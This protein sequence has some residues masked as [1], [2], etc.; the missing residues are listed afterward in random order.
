M[1]NRFVNR[2]DW[3]ATKHPV[4]RKLHFE[5]IYKNKGKRMNLKWSMKPVLTIHS[6]GLMVTPSILPTTQTFRQPPRKRIFQEDQLDSFRIH[7]KINSLDDLNQSHSPPG[8]EFRQFEGCVIFDRLKFDNDSRFPTILESIRI[9][10]ELHVQLQYNSI[11]L[12][13]PS[14]VV[15]GHSAKFDK[16]SVLE[17]FPPTLDQ[18]L[19]KINKFYLA[20]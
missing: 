7:D 16:L 4:L 15:N 9:D 17:N 8:F 14:W 6:A 1:E 19:S 13:L 3:V 20:N 11:P 12:P 10:K 2:S 18:Q 5:D